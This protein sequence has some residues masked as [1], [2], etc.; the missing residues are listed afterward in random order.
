MSAV[1][2]LKSN[3]QKREKFKKKIYN[4]YKVSPNGKGQWP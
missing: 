4:K 3:A 1:I 2:A